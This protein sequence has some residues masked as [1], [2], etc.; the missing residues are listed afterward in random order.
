MQV[1]ETNKNTSQV[2]EGVENAKVTDN[3]L[4]VDSNERNSS[5][6]IQ[7]LFHE[8]DDGDSSQVASACYVSTCN[9]SESVK[10][11][12]VDKFESE[13]KSVSVDAD[14]ADSQGVRKEETVTGANLI[15][16]DAETNGIG[17][18]VNVD[19][20][21][22]R[23]VRNRKLTSRFKDSELMAEIDLF[24]FQNKSNKMNYTGKRGH[25][26]EAVKKRKVEL[27]NVID[28]PKKVESASE[29]ICRRTNKDQSLH[30]KGN[31]SVQNDAHK[32][33]SEALLSLRGKNESE[34][35][36]GSV[37]TGQV[38]VDGNLLDTRVTNEKSINTDLENFRT[39]IDSESGAVSIGKEDKISHSETEFDDK[40]N[41]NLMDEI[42]ENMEEVFDNT[43][44][45]DTD[46]AYLKGKP[47]RPRSVRKN[48]RKRQKSQPLV[49]R[50][51]LKCETC[52]KVGSIGM[53]RYH[54]LVHS[55][56]LRYSCDVC[57]KRFTNK[58]SLRVGSAGKL[59]LFWKTY[60]LF[61]I[62]WRFE[63]LYSLTDIL[64]VL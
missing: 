62:S 11:L 27:G 48:A 53:I 5:S 56:H 28:T 32:T 57:G 26:E 58:P 35:N 31:K 50:K 19:Q 45:E 49:K 7:L 41:E 10:P 63:V 34:P 3:S 16:N 59:S 40:I 30:K 51:D 54:K 18:K 24:N 15:A 47:E 20:K 6:E 14:I 61:C 4:A 52:G 42:D 44:E 17:G 23:P 36:K 60:L 9:T 43:S 29:E 25:R 38:E 33:A 8:M 46:N 55:G 21:Y 1:N 22:S 37:D 13:E 12:N 39:I 2:S 64:T